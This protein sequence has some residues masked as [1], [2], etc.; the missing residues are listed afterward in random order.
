MV[1]CVQT[2]LYTEGYRHYIQFSV[3]N[4]LSDRIGDQA[5]SLTTSSSR[6]IIFVVVT[7]VAT[8]D[9]LRGFEPHGACRK[10]MRLSLTVLE[11][12]CAGKQACG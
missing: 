11:S 5:S 1:N 7:K 4:S 12:E 6:V 2:V 8:G 9:V 10:I 3:T